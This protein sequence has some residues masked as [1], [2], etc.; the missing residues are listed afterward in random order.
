M[1]RGYQIYF[2]CAERNKRHLCYIIAEAE[3]LV[4]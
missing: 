1:C 2:A 3:V 4:M